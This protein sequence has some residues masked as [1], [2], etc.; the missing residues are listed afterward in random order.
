MEVTC[1]RRAFR[2]A[3]PRWCELVANPDFV[4]HGAH[5]ECRAHDCFRA[6]AEDE[7]IGDAGQGDVFRLDDDVDGGVR[8]VGVVGE[9]RVFVNASEE[10]I[11]QVLI[12]GRARED[13]ELVLDALDAR[14]AGDGVFEVFLF[15]GGGD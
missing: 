3:W 8:G 7:G 14:D 5:T 4:A 11:S 12:R 9:R 2:S 13:A 10:A 6:H 1:R 15:G